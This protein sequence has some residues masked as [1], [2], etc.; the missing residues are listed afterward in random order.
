MSEEGLEGSQGK[1][2]GLQGATCDIF[3][4]SKH[5]KA[6]LQ[7][8]SHTGH[9]YFFVGFNKEFLG[10]EFTPIFENSTN[11][12]LALVQICDRCCPNL[13]NVFTSIKLCFNFL[14]FFGLKNIIR[15]FFALECMHFTNSKTI[16]P[17]Q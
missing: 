17:K 9:T 13:G 16:L 3:T 6:G 15:F 2:Q 4:Q 8:L 14:E 12:S 5:G 10:H 11:S 1:M 7:E